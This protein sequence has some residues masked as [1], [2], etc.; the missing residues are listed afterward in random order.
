ME[1]GLWRVGWNCEPN[2]LS[3][4][5][6]EFNAQA[7]PACAGEAFTPANSVQE[8]EE[9]TRRLAKSH[10]ENFPVISLLLPRTLRQDFCNIYAFCRIA[11]D[12]ADE[13]G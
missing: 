12:L 8:A 2:A 11:D 5:L 3:M 6:W 13:M 9:W 7:V 1:G 4:H 10:Y